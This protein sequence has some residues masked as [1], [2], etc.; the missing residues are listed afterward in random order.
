IKLCV[1][2]HLAKTEIP[3]VN[4]ILE[5]LACDLDHFAYSTLQAY[6]GF[7]IPS[8]FFFFERQSIFLNFSSLSFVRGEIATL[9]LPISPPTHLLLHHFPSCATPTWPFCFSCSNS[10]PLVYFLFYPSFSF[11]F[12]NPLF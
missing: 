8:P 12:L 4:R 6:G 10:F 5:S 11:S 1:L 9:W 3:L 7:P 2:D